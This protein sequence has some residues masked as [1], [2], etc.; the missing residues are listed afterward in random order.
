MSI[1]LK[2]RV[3]E[4]SYAQSTRRVFVFDVDSDLNKHQIADAVAQ[5]YEVTVTNVRV[6]VVKGKA[7]RYYRNRRYENGFRSDLKKAYVTLK[8][9][10]SIPIFAAVEQAEEAQEETD[11]K[12]K[13]AKKKEEK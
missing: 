7:K 10:D 12:A 3:S 4:K 2:P 6:V 8:E 5:T 9:G 11:K 1:V 13:K